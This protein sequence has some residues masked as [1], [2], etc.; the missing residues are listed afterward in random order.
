MNALDPAVLQSIVD[1]DPDG[2][3]LFDALAADQPVIYANP[4]FARMTGYAADELVGRNLRLLQAKDGSLFWNELAIQPLKNADGRVTHF[5]GYYRRSGHSGDSGERPRIDPKTTGARDVPSTQAVPVSVVRDD[6]LT[7]LYNRQYFDELV[8]RDWAIA[9]RDG[10]CV[11]W[12][13]FDIDALGLY[14]ETF[15]RN[16]GDA[17]IRRVART[18][19]AHFR[20]ASDLTARY[21]GGTVIAAGIGMTAELAA[22]HARIIR[23]KVAELHIH[24]PRCTVQK[25]ITVSGGITTGVPASQDSPQANIEK[26]MAALKQAKAGGRN[27]IQEAP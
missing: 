21:D 8:R 12:F 1:S 22:Q 15:G 26:V 17:C 25:F 13:I 23:D 20:R 24:H 2:V 18:I 6:R 4:A 27:R 3:V 14:N 16:A 10:R 19:A 9:Q 5:V 11:A 7:G